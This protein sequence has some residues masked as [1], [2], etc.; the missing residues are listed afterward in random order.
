MKWTKRKLKDLLYKVNSAAI[1]VHK[2]IGPGLLES[3]YH[4]CMK[5]ELKLRK[6]FVESECQVPVIYKGETLETNLRCDFLVE[7]ILIVELKA[8][9]YMVPIYDAQLLTYMNLL[10]CPL[11]VLYNFNVSNIYYEGQKTMVNELYRV[12]EP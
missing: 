8:V 2:S 4:K 12:L 1:E 7:G 6:L 10:N 11:G 5:Q 3:V 9:D